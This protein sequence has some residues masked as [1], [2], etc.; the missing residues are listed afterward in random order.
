MPI[1]LA[2]ERQRQEDFKFMASLG[3][4]KRPALLEGVTQ[5]QSI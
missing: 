5:W 3:Y 1:T 2:F 4:L